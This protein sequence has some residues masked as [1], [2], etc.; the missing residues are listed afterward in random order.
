M[1]PIDI[2]KFQFLSHGVD[3]K[4]CGDESVRLVRYTTPEQPKEYATMQR[5]MSFY[6]DSTEYVVSVHLPPLR[7]LDTLV[8]VA[9]T[10]ANCWKVTVSSLSYTD[11]ITFK[12][13]NEVIEMFKSVFGA[14]SN[15][16]C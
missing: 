3:I 14:N 1:I 5:R 15:L 16:R 9:H 13:L 4:R 7:E 12:T 10:S 11:V 6:A 2:G 8:T